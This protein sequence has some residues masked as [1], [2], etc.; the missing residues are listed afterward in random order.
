ME[1]GQNSWQFFVIYIQ[2]LSKGYC[3]SN[4][5]YGA[6]I[7]LHYDLFFVPNVQIEILA[8][9]IFD[10]RFILYFIY[11]YIYR[12]KERKLLII[13]IDFNNFMTI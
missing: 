9:T 8:K 12:K 7:S 11:I 4:V 6:L 5:I 13:Y 1:S 10:V 2:K 3:N